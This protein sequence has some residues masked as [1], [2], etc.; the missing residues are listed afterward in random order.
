MD[1]DN[2]ENRKRFYFPDVSQMYAM[3]GD[4]SQYWMKTQICTDGDVGDGFRSLPIP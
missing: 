4:H 2:L 1:E 3:V